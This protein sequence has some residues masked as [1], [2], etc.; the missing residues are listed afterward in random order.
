[1]DLGTPALLFGAIAL[2]MLAYTNRFF[3][4]AK[5]I[6]DIHANANSEHHELELK[7]VPS[8]RR[9]LL[10]IQAMQ[11]LGVLSFLLCTISIF[12]CLV[13]LNGVGA[14]LFGASVLCL[15]CSLLC[16]LWEVLVSTSAL[17]MVLDDL[18][19]QKAGE[20]A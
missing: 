15:M 10:L 12:L 14:Y 1:M 13:G 7:Q 17:G 5:L 6:R 2:V 3:V 19:K 11:A 18:A 8:L 16:S 9:R 20:K 4:L